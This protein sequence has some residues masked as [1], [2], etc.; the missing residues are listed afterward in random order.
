M[1]NHNY[2]GRIIRYRLLIEH[3]RFPFLLKALFLLIIACSLPESEIKAQ[4]SFIDGKKDPP[5]VYDETPVLV[6][7]EGYKN[8]YLYVL[9][10]NNDLLYVNIEDLFETLKIPCIVGQKG[11]SISGFI[12]DESRTYLI[13]YNTKQIKFGDKTVDLKNGLVK[14]MGAIYME[15]SLFAEAFGIKLIFSYRSLSMVLKSTFELPVIK[16]LRIEKLRSNESKLKG[17]EFADT[18][19]QRNYHLFK[20]GM[21]DWSIGSSQTFNGPTDYR[22]ILGVGAELLY[23]EADISVNYYSQQIIDDRALQFLWRWVDND[24]EIVKQAQ[25]GNISIQTIAFINSPIIGAIIRNTPT[26][27]RKARG[28]YTINEIT[29]PNWTIELYINDVLVGYTKSDASGLFVFKVPIV[30]GY[31]TLKLKFYGPMGEERTEER[32]RN[33]PYTVMPAKEFEYCL[34]AG[35]L[36]DSTSS[37]FGKAEIN[38]GVNRFITVGGGLE[39]LSS[40]S[41]G[42]FI[43]YAKA[44]IQPFS[45]LIVN[46]EYAYGVRTRALLDYYFWK[47][48][49]LE[50]DYAKYVDGQLA[51]L[52]NANE[53]RKVNLSIPFRIKKLIGLAKLDYQQF[54]YKDFYYNQ[55]M[56]MFSIYYKQL[57]ANSSTQLNWID[58]KTPYV[59][60]DLALSYRLKKGYT[61]SASAQYDV[62]AGNIISCKVEIEKRIAKAYVSASYQRNIL[63]NEN[64]ITLNFTYDLPFARTNISASYNQGNVNIYEG[65]QGSLAF[66]GGNNTIHVS[67]NSSVGRGGILLYPFLDLNNN[68]IFDEG[69][70]MVKLNSVKIFGGRASF[71]EKDSIVR[72]SDLNAFVN[73]NVEFNDYDLENIAWRF[74]HKIFQ[75]LIDPNQF[76]RIDIPI[77]TVCEVSG[78]VFLN[79]E[80]TLKGF[81][82]ILVK[83]YRKNS[84][85]VVEEILSESD[86]Y[87][88]YMGLEPGE[89]V[90][91][92]DSDQLRNLGFTADP[93][94]RDFTIK[95]LKEGDIIGD[96]NFVL[97]S[98]AK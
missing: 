50:V 96:I 76:K 18:V 60:S 32:T 2:T 45:K 98:D 66:G 15:S 52:S 26:T 14:E 95:T 23:G 97:R 4:A 58:Q 74:K 92:I 19:V 42:A 44:T 46:G 71:S 22:F 21:L 87:I 65:A 8:F 83:I 13:D 81:G 59:T 7:V 36:E 49:L 86:G 28:Y 61:L 88:D 85:K 56:L 64:F 90:A 51:T 84:D 62:N 54:I 40:I 63:I 80:N 53:E 43:P 30:Y 9:Y 78:M 10:T 93:P 31:T 6:I 25:V 91:R 5:F 3:V 39:Y 17:E 57:S 89:Y 70:P 73:Y 67:N 79:Y 48:A 69:E 47:D 34:S 72:I 38:Y 33:V 82:R 68:G 16:Q 11:D 37:R 75:V 1:K 55:G 12:E 27:V 41:N 24:K 77:I 29:E 20:P 35:I 94:Q